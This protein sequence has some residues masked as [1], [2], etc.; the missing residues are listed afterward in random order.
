M[1]ASDKANFKQNNTENV[2]RPLLSA[3]NTGRVRLRQMERSGGPGPTISRHS[4]VRG[5]EV[6]ILE[7]CSCTGY[8]QLG[9]RT[10]MQ[11][12]WW[13]NYVWP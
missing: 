4:R 12:W 2:S 10:S 9:P 5:P 6:R 1:W 3:T 11:T 13:S 7:S 8:A